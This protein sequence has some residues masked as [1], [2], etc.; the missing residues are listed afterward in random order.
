MIA[1]QGS[2]LVN[3]PCNRQEMME[4]NGY[5]IRTEFRKNNLLDEDWRKN[6]IFI[7]KNS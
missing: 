6:Y 1:Q 3:T 4:D 2:G 7:Q 5:C